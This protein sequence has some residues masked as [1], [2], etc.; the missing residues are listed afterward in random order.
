MAIRTVMKG[1]SPEYLRA[2][3]KADQAWEMAGLARQDG[4]RADE[5]RWT[6]EAREWERKAAQ[7]AAQEQR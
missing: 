5:Q 3:R 2:R 6:D 7:A 1:S 4:D